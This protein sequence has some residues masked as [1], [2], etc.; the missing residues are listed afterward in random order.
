MEPKHRYFSKLIS[1]IFQL[2]VPRYN[3]TGA[4]I[5]IEIFYIMVLKM[6]N[7]SS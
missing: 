3:N 6:Q 7:F 2:N 1:L 4:R 5:L